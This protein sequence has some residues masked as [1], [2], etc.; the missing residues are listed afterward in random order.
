M[1]GGGWCRINA[2]R[3]PPKRF[4]IRSLCGICNRTGERRGFTTGL[5]GAQWG[6]IGSTQLNFAGAAFRCSINSNEN[7]PTSVGGATYPNLDYQSRH[8]QIS[9]NGRRQAA[10]RPAGFGGIEAFRV[11]G[12]PASVSL[13]NNTIENANNV[14]PV[15]FQA[16]TTAT[17]TAVWPDGRVSITELIE[18]SRT[19]CFTGNSG[20]SSSATI[21]AAQKR[22]DSM[23]R[24]GENFVIERN[25]Y[26]GSNHRHRAASC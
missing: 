24:T 9:S 3:T 6:L 21:R 8:R 26:S 7:N 15:V 12:V 25:L 13:K 16:S 23:E 11:V 22:A 5:R 1:V 10:G 17:R 19:T 20:G 2:R 4:L 18:I 14:G